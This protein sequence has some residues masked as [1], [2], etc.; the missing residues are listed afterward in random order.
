MKI[1]QETMDIVEATP[2]TNATL[3]TIG[4]A[5]A[6]ATAAQVFKNM[7]GATGETPLSQCK[8]KA[9]PFLVGL[10]A[11]SQALKDQLSKR[12]KE[13]SAI[14]RQLSQ[15]QQLRVQLV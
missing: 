12:E 1:A 14:Q 11:E 9:M 3:T 10:A 13:L 15:A 8:E 4:K 7:A 5:F 2:K 6:V